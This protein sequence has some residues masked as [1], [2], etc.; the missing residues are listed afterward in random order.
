MRPPSKSAAWSLLFVIAMLMISWP[1]ATAAEQ[2]HERVVFALSGTPDCGGIPDAALIADI[3]GNLYGS[4]L[5]GGANGQGCIFEL[6]PTHD[7]WVE[8]PLYSFPG[9]PEGNSPRSALVFDK[10]GNLY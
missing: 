4:T 5:R 8:T 2:H 7:G 1:V 6:S 3:H 10:A 9:S